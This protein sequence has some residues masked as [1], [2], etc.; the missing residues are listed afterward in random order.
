MTSA[1][2]VRCSTITCT[3]LDMVKFY[4]RARRGASSGTG[5]L[6]TMPLFFCCKVMSVVIALLLRLGFLSRRRIKSPNSA[7]FHGRVLMLNAFT[8]FLSVSDPDWSLSSFSS[9]SDLKCSD[10]AW[11][12]ASHTSCSP[13][14]LFLENHD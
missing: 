3:I 8:R 9:D 4:V 2:P 13:L 5:R 10:D 14:F 1:I 12:I 7:P 6:G 11:S